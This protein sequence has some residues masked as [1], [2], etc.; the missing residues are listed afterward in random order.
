[1]FDYVLVGGKEMIITFLC[2]K[3]SESILFWIFFAIDILPKDGFN[4]YFRQARLLQVYW[5]PVITFELLIIQLSVKK[6]P[7]S[8]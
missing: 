6:F 1:M 3:E 5:Y 7:S 4:Q 8:H 2:Y